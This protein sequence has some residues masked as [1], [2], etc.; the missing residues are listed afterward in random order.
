MCMPCENLSDAED[1]VDR[2]ETAYKDVQNVIN[3]LWELHRKEELDQSMDLIDA[4]HALETDVQDGIYKAKT[5]MEELVMHR[6]R[7]LPEDH[8]I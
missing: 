5:E 3:E 1:L 2:L 8:R 7:N 6:T 4:I